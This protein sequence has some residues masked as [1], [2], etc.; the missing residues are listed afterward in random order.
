MPSTDIVAREVADRLD[1]L[2]IVTIT[3]GEVW[4]ARDL[5]PFAGYA[6]W[7]EFNDAINRAKASVSASGLNPADHFG[8][9]PKMVEIG[10]GARRQ[11]EDV[12]LTRYGCYI[13]FQNADAR[14]P[15]IAALQSYFA[16]QTRKQELAPATDFDP[17][18]IDGARLILEAA[19]T[20]LA[21]VAELEPKAEAWD[22]L[23]TADGDYPVSEASKM[24]ARAGIITGP[25]RLFDQLEQ[26]GWIFRNGHGVWEPYSEI[27]GRGY[28]ALKPQSHPHPRTG[29]RIIDPPQVRLTVKGI[30]RLRVRLHTSEVAA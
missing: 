3:D 14:K 21:R 12:E 25:Q 1:D 16:V 23:A 28:M 19:A 26:L 22:E 17:T 9:A 6:N 18:T 11:V 13:L 5:M 15:E 4:S 2:R 27:V 8:D 24:L 30:D 7:R 29:E 10:S 20:A